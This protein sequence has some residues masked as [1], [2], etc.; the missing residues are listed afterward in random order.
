MDRKRTASVSYVKPGNYKLLVKKSGYK[1]YKK[2][3][4]IPDDPVYTIKAKLRKSIIKLDWKITG[5]YPKG[6]E[7]EPEVVKIDGKDVYKGNSI[8]SGIH[9]V[10]I[11]H[12][13]Y[14]IYRKQIVVP[15][16]VSRYVLKAELTTLP[17]LV[18]ANISYDVPPSAEVARRLGPCRV[19]LYKL[20]T[21]DKVLV[22]QGIK[23]KPEKYEVLITRRAY[24]NVKQVVYIWPKGRPF[25]IKAMLQAK[26][27]ILKA[28]VR[29]DIAAP[30]YLKPYIVDFVSAKGVARTVKKNGRVKP[31][32]QRYIVR[33]EGYKM[34]GGEKT[35]YIEPS[36][37]PY[38]L[39][40]VELKAQS[41]Q[42]S[43]NIV[44][45]NVIQDA[46]SITVDG[47]VYSYNKT[48]QPGK[49][50]YIVAKFKKFKTVK[51]N[52]TFEPGVGPH[53]V[54]LVLMPK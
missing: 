11:Q 27:R 7:F 39:E 43:F 33:K 46:E 17:R 9:K 42:L 15:D 35:A 51:K 2:K 13:G 54:K 34:V 29:H 32:K 20:I 48:Y 5:E 10:V 3:V 6:E 50:Y 21:G 38:E 45:N 16:G 53:V 40:E 28:K 30:D 52:I 23:V 14:E 37:E 26:T 18:V 36:E 44:Y 24:E 47:E 1:T 49:K 4:R 41:R 8:S 22:K 19:Q 12:P 25:E 31:G